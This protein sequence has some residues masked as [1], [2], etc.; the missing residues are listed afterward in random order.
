MDNNDL[1]SLT[2][3]YANIKLY[4]SQYI[5]LLFIYI[6]FIYNIYSLHNIIIFSNSILSIFIIFTFTT[7]ILIHSHALFFISLL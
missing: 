4:N 1:R 5:Y 7:L 3:F 2:L 6:I